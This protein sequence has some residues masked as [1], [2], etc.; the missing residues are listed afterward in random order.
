MAPRQPLPNISEDDL[1]D[2]AGGATVLLAKELVAKGKVKKA[3]WT[4]PVAEAL[5]DD[6]TESREAR[7][8]LR[9]VTFQ[10][11]EC[12]CEVSVGRR[13][14]CVHSVAAYLVLANKEG[15]LK[16]ETMAPPKPAAPPGKPAIATTTKEKTADTKKEKSKEAETTPAGPRLKSLTLS[17]KRG[18]PIEVRFIVPPNIV[19]AAARDEI[20]CRLELRVDGAQVAPENLD[21][22][23]AWTIEP[24]TV[25]FLA[26]LE[27]LCH[28]KL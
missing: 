11:N 26:I 24:D 4:P 12:G 5:V 1:I 9:S 6:G 14:L 22:S 16:P 25:F 27:N 3:L 7:W 21:R 17:E 20:I 18:A 10:R 23:K 2:L 19:T 15:Y 13:K 28:G 8:N